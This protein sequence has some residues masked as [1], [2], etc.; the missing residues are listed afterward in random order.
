MP[1]VTWAD[2]PAALYDVAPWSWC[3]ITCSQHHLLVPPGTW[4]VGRWP[5]GGNLIGRP[6]AGRYEIFQHEAS[7]WL[8]VVGGG[9]KLRRVSFVEHFL[10]G[11]PWL[12]K[13][14]ALSTFSLPT[15]EFLTSA[16]CRRRIF[17]TTKVLPW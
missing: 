6:A 2:T 9:G 13:S 7:Q 10:L 5:G 12:K 1:G 17:P 16:L 15:G 8:I 3:T 11:W 4:T 14:W